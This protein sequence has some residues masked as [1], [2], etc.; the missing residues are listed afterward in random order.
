MFFLFLRAL[1]LPVRRAGHRPLGRGE[2]E[3]G[4]YDWL[5]FPKFCEVNFLLSFLHLGIPCPDLGGSAK[6][7]CVLTS[8]PSIFCV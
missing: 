5:L 1:P 4:V 8:A 2:V 3:E 7:V 6:K